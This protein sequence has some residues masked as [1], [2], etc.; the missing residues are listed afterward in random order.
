MTLLTKHI[1]FLLELQYFF[2][3]L[4]QKKMIP[5]NFFPYIKTHLYL[6]QHSHSIMGN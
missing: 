1:K 3:D 4:A 2:N 6:K 5:G